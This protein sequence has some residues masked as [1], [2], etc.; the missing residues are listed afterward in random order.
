LAKLFKITNPEEKAFLEALPEQ[1]PACQLSNEEVIKQ[2]RAALAE[3]SDAIGLHARQI[4]INAI[5]L[6][7]K[8]KIIIMILLILPIL[9][10]QEISGMRRKN[11][12]PK[13]ILM[14]K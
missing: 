9:D 8:Q 4:G 2:L 11:A 13:W 3:L 7:L 1:L 12:F 5:F 14:T 10:C 6:S